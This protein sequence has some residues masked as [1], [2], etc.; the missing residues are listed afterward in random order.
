MQSKGRT[1]RLTR[2]SITIG[3][4][5]LLLS[6]PR[7][8]H[9]QVCGN[10]AV[11]QG[12]ECDPGG[13]LHE[14]G[15]PNL[16]TC[17][18]G[19]SGI[20]G[21]DCF[22]AFSCCKFNCQFA[23]PGP[24][25]DGNLCTTFDECNNVGQCLGNAFAAAGTACG[26]PG[27]T[28][29]DDPDTCDGAGTCTPNHLAG[30][31][32]CGDPADSDCD[33]ADTCDGAGACDDN[34]QAPGTPAPTQCHDANACTGDVCDGAGGCLNPDEPAGTACGDP[35]DTDCDD[36]DTCDGAGTCLT[37]NASDGTTCDDGLFCTNTDACAGGVCA[38]TGDPCAGGPPCLDHCNEATTDCVAPSGTDCD[39]D[40]DPCSG[41]AE[42]DGAGTCTPGA[43]L[44]TGAPCD[45]GVDCTLLDSCRG[46][47]CAGAG[48]Y[49]AE[50][51]MKVSNLAIVSSDLIAF[52]VDGLASIGKRSEMADG[53]R[54]VGAKV[55][56]S[57]G[58]SVFDV[59]ADTV[60]IG[61]GAEIRGTQSPATLPIEPATCG[62]RPEPTC[63]VTAV[64]VAES[65]VVEL[66]PG[67]YGD[68]NMGENSTLELAPGHYEFCNVLSGRSVSI[69]AQAGGAVDVEVV[70]S[71]LLRNGS[72]FAPAPGGVRPTLWL[73]GRSARI[74]SGGFVQ[75]H[76]VAPTGI[77]KYGRSTLVDGTTCARNVKGAWNVQLTCVE[78]P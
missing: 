45:D 2:L 60:K 31:T 8:A 59:E 64:T 56:L 13:P 78:T 48:A 5:C 16:P 76:V 51:R 57:P 22:Y 1:L 36:P 14:Q 19:G 50:R 74:G 15:N 17:G 4:G 34:V 21:S 32:P 27:A 26:D 25:F 70:E 37:N 47:Q 29:C 66:A 10:G 12:E 55:K 18:D 42:C 24:C 39:A 61:S 7:I 54:I 40:G 68:L 67:I 35:A 44:A 3:L 77:V 6:S 65:E 41:T 53:T 72:S 69:V 11:E 20:P 46:G 33:A 49:A 58:A 62:T 9:A 71:L 23:N 38:G 73:H 30:G 52:D 28:D 75:A 43:P 63:G